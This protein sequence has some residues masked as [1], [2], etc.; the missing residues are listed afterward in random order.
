MLY[1]FKCDLAEDLYDDFVVTMAH[2][3]DESMSRSFSRTD[4]IV[5]TDSSLDS[6]DDEVFEKPLDGEEPHV[7]PDITT[8]LYR[9]DIGKR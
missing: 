7:A 6:A 2:P 9:T 1:Y 3:R 4:S 5:S 8:E